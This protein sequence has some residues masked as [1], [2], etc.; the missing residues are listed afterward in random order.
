M[1]SFEVTPQERAVWALKTAIRKAAQEVDGA[2]IVHE[3]IEGLIYTRRETLDDPL[4][5]VRAARL[6]RDVAIGELRR[7][8]EQARGAGRSWDDVAAAL[9]IEPTTGGEPRD[10]QA[11]LLVVERRPLP[12]LEQTTWSRRPIARWTCRAC[13]QRIS[14]YGPF[15]S[16]PDDVERGHDSRCIRHVATFTDYELQS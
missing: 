11:Y 14:D 1:S 5:G 6:A 10:E 8:A 15:E 16:H 4:A 3:P 7:Y 13:G 9:T 12:G 2:E